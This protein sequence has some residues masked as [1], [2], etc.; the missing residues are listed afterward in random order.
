MPDEGVISN[1]LGVGK[2]VLP[3][4]IL[5]SIRLSRLCVPSLAQPSAGTRKLKVMGM[6]EV[7]IKV[8]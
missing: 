8:Q 4:L 2:M 5:L 7:L 1:S 6:R 3:S